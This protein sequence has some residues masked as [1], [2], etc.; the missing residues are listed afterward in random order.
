LEA[1]IVWSLMDNF[2][3]AD[4]YRVRFGLIHVDYGSQ[5]R[6]LKSSA[7]WFAGV[8]AGNVIADPI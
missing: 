7:H 8:I 1:Y 5:V 4:G 3:W 2:E 6:L